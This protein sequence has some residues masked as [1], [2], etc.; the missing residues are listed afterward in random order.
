MACWCSCS[1]E[2][3]QLGRQRPLDR[4]GDGV[5]LAGAEREQD[6]V[7]GGEDRAEALGEDVA[8]DLGGVGEERAVVGCGSAR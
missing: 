7:A 2:A 1:T 4:G 8:G 6:E 5:G 3:G